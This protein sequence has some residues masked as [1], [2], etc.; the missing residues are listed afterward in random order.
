MA[1]LNKINKKQTMKTDDPSDVQNDPNSV[2]DAS[3][4]RQLTS[5]MTHNSAVKT[6][7]NPISN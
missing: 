6:R 7:Q 5:S 3:V 1:N 2:I 4:F